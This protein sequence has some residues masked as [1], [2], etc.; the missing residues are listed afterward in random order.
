M[1][2]RGETTSG[3]SAGALTAIHLSTDHPA[4][5]SGA[6]TKSAA[7]SASIGASLNTAVTETATFNASVDTLREGLVAAPTAVEAT[8]A[9]GAATVAT[10]GEVFTI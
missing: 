6:D 3:A 2:I 5:P 1:N 8:D 4:C 7:I 10:S 9:N